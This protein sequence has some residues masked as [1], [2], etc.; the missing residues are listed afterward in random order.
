MKVFKG[1]NQ[2]SDD[3]LKLR[4]GMPTAS[5]V[6][7]LMAKGSGKTRANY[8]DKLISEI[9]LGSVGDEIKTIHMD[10]GNKTEPQARSMYELENNIDVKQV[11]FVIKENIFVGCSPDGLIGESG[12][13][14]I[15][16]PKTETQLKTYK[17]G[18][19]PSIHRAQI[20]A[21]IWICER[22]WCDFVSYDPRIDGEGS[23]FQFREFR[24]DKK[25]SDIE[26]A[27][28]IFNDEILSKLNE[29]GITWQKE[30]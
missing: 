12:L 26:Q 5:R 24:D 14:E 11:A 6:K 9:L 7:D 23:Y 15:K 22:E 19:I 25:I 1:I 29:W 16:C 18:K 20:Q 21:Q 3:W 27:V 13:I 28:K 30:Q 17:M 4:L 8:M 2:G 10:W